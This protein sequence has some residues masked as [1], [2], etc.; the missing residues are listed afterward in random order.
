M[1]GQPVKSS[2]GTMAAKS[3]PLAPRPCSQM[4][5]AVGLG[6]DSI[7]M[8]SRRFV[9][10]KILSEFCGIKG[11]C[12]EFHTLNYLILHAEYGSEKLCVSQVTLFG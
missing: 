1:A 11:K 3:S 10:F 8:R 5:A 7:S 2:S 6:A 9:I 12:L 4:M